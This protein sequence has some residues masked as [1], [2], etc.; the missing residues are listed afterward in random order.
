MF[1]HADHPFHL[2]G[3]RRLQISSYTAIRECSLSAL[4]FFSFQILCPIHSAHLDGN[5]KFV[6]NT[7][8]FLANLLRPFEHQR[9]IV[10]A[11]PLFSFPT[12]FSISRASVCTVPTGNLRARRRR[13]A[14][15]SIFR[16]P[17]FVTRQLFNT[18]LRSFR[19]SA[20]NVRWPL[21]PDLTPT[22]LYTTSAGVWVEAVFEAA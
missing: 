12:N 2:A 3:I 17:H 4:C 1:P 15:D 11:S 9:H 21:F 19:L 14:N 22:T 20:R 13:P 18:L 5:L 7:L 6:L 16:L 10:F 8:S